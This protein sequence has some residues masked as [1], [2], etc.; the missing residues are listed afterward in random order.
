MNKLIP[1][2]LGLMLPIAG[3][4]ADAFTDKAVDFCKSNGGAATWG[5]MV[6]EGENYCKQLTCKRTNSDKYIINDGDKGPE[7]NVE[8][9][10]RVCVPKSSIDGTF[11]AKD[12]QGSAGGSPSGSGNGNGNGNGNN[13]NGNGNGNGNGNNNNG[14]GNGNNNNGNG[15]GNGNGNNNNGSSSGAV[16]CEELE[17]D[18]KIEPSG[19][20]YDECKPKSAWYTFG[21]GEKKSGFERTS[22]V[23][24]LLKYPG[25]YKVKREYLPKDADGKVIG[26]N[27]VD[28]G[29]GVTIKSGIKVCRDSSGR[30]VS[31]SGTLNGACPAGSVLHTSDGTPVIVAPNSGSTIVSGG[32]NGT[33]TIVIT[34]SGSDSSSGSNSTQYPAYCNSSKQK[35]I[36]ACDVWMKKYGRFGCSSSSSASSCLR[37]DYNDILARYDGCENCKAASAARQQSTGSQIAEVVAS[38]TP[39]LGILGSSWLNYRGVKAQADAQVKVAEQCVIDNQNYTTYLSANELAALTPAQKATMMCN[40]SSSSAFANYGNSGILSLL[41]S[42]YSNAFLSGMAGP[43]GYNPYGQGGMINGISLA[44]G[45]MGGIGGNV[46]AIYGGAGTIYGGNVGTI[47][48]GNAGT[49]Y[50]GVNGAIYGGIGGNVGTIYGGNVG[51]IYGGN[52]G[53][54]YGGVNGTIYGGIGGNVGTIYGGNVGTIYGGNAGTIYGGVN[55]T[56]YGGIG[57]N[58]GTI[59]GGAGTI[60]GG[61]VGTIYGGNSGTIYGGVNGAIYGGIG[62]NGTIYGGAGTIYGGAGTIYGGA[63]TIY[64]GAGT[65]YGGATGTIYGG[66]GGSIYGGAG[67]GVNQIDLIG[68]NYDRQLQQQGTGYQMQ[69]LTGAAS[70]PSNLYRGW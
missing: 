49:I 62:G 3:A 46:G 17:G 70:Y 51:T 19:L 57:G 7:A 45:T 67:G 23:E 38:A 2:F 36:D 48:G 54:I 30:I 44:G 59:Y 5:S 53:T 61:N 31:S 63:G 50:G 13:N 6:E 26:D 10:K 8:A 22:C 65:I 21:F 37:G 41:N 58:V 11:A 69:A 68:A 42:G 1:L 16:A 35:D 43:Y 25:V 34:G 18:G 24:C 4:Y 20:C 55:G 12:A 29:K 32:G 40:G 47:Y 56:I 66:A 39:L 14:N 15:N 33:G 60:Y 64:G 27:S 52:A 9:T 28:L